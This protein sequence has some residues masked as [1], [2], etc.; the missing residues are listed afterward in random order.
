MWWPWKPRK[1]YDVVEYWNNRENPN[2]KNPNERNTHLHIDYVNSNID[3]QDNNGDTP[4]HL[5]VYYKR[6]DMITLLLNYGADITITNFQEDL[7][8]RGNLNGKRVD[9]ACDALH[10]AHF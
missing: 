2:S 1:K 6:Y 4:L 5:A 10:L 8:Q 9:G 7:V 3:E